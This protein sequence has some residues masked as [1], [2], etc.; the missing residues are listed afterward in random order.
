MEKTPGLGELLRYI[1]DLVDHGSEKTWREMDIAYRPRYTPILRAMAAGART[2]TDITAQ[3]WL[4]QGAISQ[5]V[6]MMEKEGILTKAA[7]ED[8]RKSSL[9]LT[10]KGEA[11]VAEA[12]PHWQTLFAAIEGLEKETGYPLLSILQETAR[13]LERQGFDE[14]IRQAK[15]TDPDAEDSP[16]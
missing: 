14:R 4:T 6:S 10:A 13:A 1:S 12:Q 3:T 16:C 7:L 2:V 9:H 8:G 11:L 15:N 5:S